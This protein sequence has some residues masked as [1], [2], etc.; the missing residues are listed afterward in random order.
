MVD[1]EI[2]C[3]FADNINVIYNEKDYYLL[4]ADVLWL[5]VHKPSE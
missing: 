1:W 5:Y 4:D 2:Y 3:I